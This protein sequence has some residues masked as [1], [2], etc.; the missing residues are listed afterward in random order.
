MKYM[1]LLEGGDGYCVNIVVICSR[2]SAI[3]ARASVSATRPMAN[4]DKF[5]LRNR[6]GDGVSAKE[7]L[8]KSCILLLYIH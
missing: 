8:V 7:L 2:S 6:S 5:W 3:G 4:F 1:M